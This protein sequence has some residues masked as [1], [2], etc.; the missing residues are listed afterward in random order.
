MGLEPIRAPGLLLFP[1]ILHAVKTDPNGPAAVFRFAAIFSRCDAGSWTPS[2]PRWSKRCGFFRR[3]P[4]TPLLLFSIPHPLLP[5]CG[6]PKTGNCILAFPFP[7]RTWSRF[8]LRTFFHSPASKAGQNGSAAAGLQ[9]FG[10]VRRGPFGKTPVQRI[11]AARFFCCPE[12]NFFASPVPF[13]L[14]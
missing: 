7:A 8:M 10:F 9:A 14:T 6:F 4:L 5:G 3:S 2:R 13:P 12:G 11:R 1:R